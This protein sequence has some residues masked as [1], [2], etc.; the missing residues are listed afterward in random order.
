VYH[1]VEYHLEVC[2]HSRAAKVYLAHHLAALCHLKVV[3]QWEVL[4]AQC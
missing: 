3:H 1:Q 2:Y 4:V